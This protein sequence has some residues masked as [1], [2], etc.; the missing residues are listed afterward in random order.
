L[1]HRKGQEAD[2]RLLVEAAQRA[3][4]RWAELYELHVHRGYRYV[5]RRAESREE[6]EDITSELFQQALP[7]SEASKGGAS[8][9]PPG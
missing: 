4:L 2:E 5:L 8:R 1:K 3:P 6:S 7:K 9:F